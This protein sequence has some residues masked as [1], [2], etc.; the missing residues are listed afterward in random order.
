M[1]NGIPSLVESYIS[2]KQSL[3]FQITSES[4]VLRSFARYVQKSWEV[5]VKELNND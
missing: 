4:V 5:D 1:N 3:G 2:Y